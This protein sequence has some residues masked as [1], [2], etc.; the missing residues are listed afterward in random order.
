[1]S[2]IKMTPAPGAPVGPQAM[3]VAPPDTTVVHP[4]VGGSID[5]VRQEIND[6][7]EEM[8]EFYNNEPDFC[9]RVISGQAARLSYITSRIRRIDDFNP[10][11]K[12]VRERELEPLL[13]QLEFQYD[14]ASRRHTAREFDWKVETGER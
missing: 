10:D 14:I 1:M 3:R 6:A 9:M 12:A 13:R 4:E 8:Q 5:S 11:W 7:Y 2:T